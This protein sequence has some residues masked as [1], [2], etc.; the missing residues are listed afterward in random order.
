M[1][2]AAHL[3]TGTVTF[4][5]SDVEGSTGLLQRLATGYKQVIER[6]A[7]IIRACL[8]A[9]N[10][11][12]IST[13]GDSFFAVFTAAPDAVAAAGAV[14]QRLAATNWPDGGNVAV[15]IGL[16]TG[17]GELGHDN[18]YGIDVNRA[19]RISAT[20]H[21]GQVVVSDAVR[22]LAPST[23]FTDLGEHKLKGLD[24]IEHLYQLDV[25]G[26]PET[27]PPLRTESARPNN[28]P[29]L[30]T[31]ILGR[32][33]EI[34]SLMQMLG[35]NRLVTITGPGGIG[36]TR[37]AL[38]VASDM[39]T[40]F[41]RGAF[42]VDLAPIDD[43]E[44]VLPEI[45]A[46]VGVDYA[47]VDQLAEALA[48]GPRLVVLDNF[49]QV[50]A[51]A[52]DL[53]SVLSQAAPI[54]MLTTS[55]LPLRLAGEQVFR[56]NPLAAAG[57]DN[58]AIEL[59]AARARQ[60][61]P[62][63]DLTIHRTDVVELV[64]ALEGV[65]LA[66]EL[67][68]ARVNVLTPRQV[69]ERL[70]AGLG[71]LK[72][73]RSDAPDRHRSISAAIAWSY[74]LLTPVQQDLLAALAV[75]RGGATLPALEFVAD[76]DPIDD[77]A[78]LVDRSLVRTEAGTI[79][80]R[81]LLLAPVQAFIED[82]APERETLLARHSQFFAD[83]AAQARD[84]LERDSRARWLAILGDDHDNIRATLDHL[85][86]AG[87]TEQ[88]Y[89]LLGDIWRFFHSSGQLTELELWLSRVFAADPAG[90]PTRGRTKALLA[91]AAIF[92]WRSEWPACVA[93]YEAAA[94][95]AEALEDRPLLAESLSGLG[96]GLGNAM[97]MGQQIGDPVPPMTRAYEIFS[98]LGDTA[99]L[100]SIEMGRVMMESMFG[101]E[102]TIPDRAK[103]QRIVEMYREAGS[104]M[105]VAHTQGMVAGVHLLEGNYVDAYHQ[106]IEALDTAEQAGDTFAMVQAVG[107]IG[108]TTVHLG[109]P[110]LGARLAGAA[111]RAGEEMGGQWVENP[112]F[113]DK[114]E[115]LARNVIG[116]EADAAFE[117]G[118][119]MDL[120]E[121]IRQAREDVRPG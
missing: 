78:E 114:A 119:E 32:E 37:L 19:A 74:D 28:L 47:G 111:R 41:E 1:S 6:H 43:A 115:D 40:R 87:E 7:E 110:R 93:D 70:G 27:F 30:A 113:R 54:K 29:T 56:L 46:T 104:L 99:N 57:D 55:Q 64:D 8:A 49:E 52:P 26:L 79:G 65:P 61:D 60:A 51:A 20:G 81:F 38:E 2:G 77:L 24:Q 97:A 45:A 82:R 36:K 84:P 33:D 106:I 22:A 23:V 66:I 68:A 112:F 58:P 69:L 10:G 59:F 88:V 21:G 83:L 44:L 100:A 39:L 9:H 94:A 109:D 73:S 48:D 3:P 91:R 50:V 92:Y 5:F 105:F 76:G 11:T 118:R 53:G 34:A 71:V 95:I 102:P 75:F 96:G 35:E 101:P 12:E 14:Q 85:L 90:A 116:A 117:E 67:A 4:F 121:A 16:H 98:E 42:L 31:R 25:D 107:W 72:T 120:V 13:E 63:F 62:G 17:A 18:Y 80:K 86:A 89:N 103:L 108:Y 15:R